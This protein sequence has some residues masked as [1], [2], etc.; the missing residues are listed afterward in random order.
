MF[1]EDESVIAEE[2]RA[3]A[4]KARRAKRAGRP[5][6]GNDGGGAHFQIGRVHA[7]LQIRYSDLVCERAERS[8][9]SRRFGVRE[10][11]GIERTRKR[12]GGFFGGY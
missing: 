6:I 9:V 11:S 10:L 1:Q 4:H 5:G 12:L 7:L 8:V 2:Q 3:V